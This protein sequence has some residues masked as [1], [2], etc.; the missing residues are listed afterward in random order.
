MADLDGF[1]WLPSGMPLPTF[2]DIGCGFLAGLLQEERLGGGYCPIQI[3]CL[4]SEARRLSMSA[5]STG[6][7]LGPV[8]CHSFDHDPSQRGGAIAVELCGLP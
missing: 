5:T 2:Y 1:L 7:A 3:P 4:G 8:V 6:V